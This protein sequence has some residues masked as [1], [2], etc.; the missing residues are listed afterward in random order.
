MT[1]I[2]ISI[3]E[4]SRSKQRLMGV[5]SP[6]ER[7]ELVL[8]MLNDLLTAVAEADCGPVLVVASDDAV[9]DI[10]H[11]F[12][13]RAVK[14]HEVRGYN[15]AASLGI[16]RAG[17]GN[18]AVL[19]GDIPL[20]AADEIN[21][22]CAPAD[23]DSRCLRLAASHDRRGTNGVFL[24]A[25]DLIRPG[26]GSNSLTRYQQTARDAGIEPTLLDAPGLARDIDTPKDLYE[27]AQCVTQ[28]A[29]SAFLERIRH[30]LEHSDLR[31]GVA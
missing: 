25:R 15:A 23:E 19:P 5:L 31:R 27:L 2:I 8:V 24:A 3:K 9:F 30:K 13:A 22:L 7:A 18:V 12:G 16:A 6:A 20:A 11:E 28:G 21:C 4:L 1:T 14:E 10:A 29:T 26:F 17:N